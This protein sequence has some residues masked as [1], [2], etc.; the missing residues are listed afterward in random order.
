MPFSEVFLHALGILVDWVWLIFPF[1]FLHIGW[2][3]WV[4]YW[5]LKMAEGIY[6][7]LVFLRITLPQEILSTP[8]SME[9]VFHNLHGILGYIRPIDQL[10]WRE[11][12]PWMSMEILGMNGNM[13]FIIAVPKKHRQILQIALYSE[14]PDIEIDEVSD[15]TLTV[16]LDVPNAEWN[17]HGY[18]WVLN[19]EDIWRIKTYEDW[20]IDIELKPERNID[21]IA[22]M[23]ELCSSLQPGEYLWFQLLISPAPGGDWLD[24][25]KAVRFDFDRP[26]PPEP[27]QIEQG[28]QGVGDFLITLVGGTPADESKEQERFRFPSTLDRNVIEVLGSKIERPSFE[29][30]FRMIYLAQREVYDRSRRGSIR[31]FVRPF[32]DYTNNSFR[33]HEDTETRI[34]K[35]MSLFP[36][37]RI[38]IKRRRL[39]WY[40]R[41]RYLRQDGNE[42]GE[43]RGYH[44]PKESI[45]YHLNAQELATI[46]HFP[47][48]EVAAPGLRRLPARKT[49]PP[50]ELPTI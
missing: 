44:F 46:Y 28:F 34:R 13:Y 38:N 33:S 27:S 35:F 11:R 10:L 32:A 31:G 41:M 50:V 37:T 49:R 9:Q 39:L 22:Q 20:K 4:S 5:D 43:V 2:Y 14:Y 25:A 3:M 45:I 21:P 1:A 48:K 7:D 8:K 47:G 36:E 17:L 15:Y 18:D 26:K 23:A 40:Y 42:A 16:P 6:S 24:K 29:V 12:Q 30:N 19:D